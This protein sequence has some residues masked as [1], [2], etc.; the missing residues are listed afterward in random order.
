M[1]QRGPATPQQAPTN[2]PGK[3]APT[4][5]RSGP[6]V[7]ATILILIAIC[8]AGIIPVYLAGELLGIWHVVIPNGLPLPYSNPTPTLSTSLIPARMLW[9]R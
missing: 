1:A 6:G 4:S 2:A 7:M 3:Q 9:P 5:T 8:V